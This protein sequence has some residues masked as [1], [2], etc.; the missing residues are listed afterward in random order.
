MMPDTYAVIYIRP[1]GWWSAG[2]GFPN[3]YQAEKAAKEEWPNATGTP[4]AGGKKPYK[5]VLERNLERWLCSEAW[6][7]YCEDWDKGVQS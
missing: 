1:D 5:I 4:W 7:D 2:A 3:R 6:E